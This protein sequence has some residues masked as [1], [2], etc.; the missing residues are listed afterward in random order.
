MVASVFRD[1][2]RQM[3][4]QLLPLD[5]AEERGKSS[6]Q[7]FG[8]LNIE[9]YCSELGRLYKYMTWGGERS[10]EVGVCNWA[11]FEIQM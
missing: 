6:C 7:Q 8:D 11:E 5:S 1:R 2:G 4:F 3:C 9:L 10:C